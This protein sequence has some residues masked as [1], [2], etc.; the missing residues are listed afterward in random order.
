MLFLQ[1]K[2]LEYSDIFFWIPNDKSTGYFHFLIQ[3][4]IIYLGTS[5]TLNYLK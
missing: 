4:N 5:Q 1:I 2:D 3:V